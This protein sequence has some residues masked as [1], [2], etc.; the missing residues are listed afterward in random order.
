MEQIPWIIATALVITMF[1]LVSI[2]ETKFNNLIK[3]S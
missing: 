1:I 3:L 2:I